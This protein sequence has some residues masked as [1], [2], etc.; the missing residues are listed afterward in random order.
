MGLDIINDN[1]EFLSEWISREKTKEQLYYASHPNSLIPK[2]EDEL[3]ALGLN[4]EISNQLL[5]YMPR[6]KKTIL[7]IAIK[8]YQKAKQENYPDEQNHFLQFFHYKGFDSVVP[9]L[10]ADYKATATAELTRWMISD[11]LYQIR[12]KDF[13]DEYIDIV[14]KPKYGI[15]RQML[16]LLLG[17]LKDDTAVPVLITLLDDHD[18]SLQAISALS[19]YRSPELRIYFERFITSRQQALKKAAI[20]ALKK[21]DT[22]K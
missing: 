22:K 15:N 6:Q 9:M 14:S 19:E 13:L 20:S 18:V 12:S 2:F 21:I 7:P 3:R 10:I 8:Y 16:V 17:K 11:C 1:P 5:G 4:F